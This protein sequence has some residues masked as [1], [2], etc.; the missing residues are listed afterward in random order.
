[1]P[2]GARQMWT[3]IYGVGQGSEG[4]RAPSCPSLH[5]AL[6]RQG[7]PIEKGPRNSS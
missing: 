1:M 5:L 4:A 6:M 3:E 7:L 2:K